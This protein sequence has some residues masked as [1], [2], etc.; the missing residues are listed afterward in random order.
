[1]NGRAHMIAG[2][3]STIPVSVLMHQVHPLPEMPT[4][5]NAVIAAAMG[6]GASVLPDLDHPRASLARKYLGPYASHLVRAA[7][8]LARRVSTT[9]DRQSFAHAERIGHDP[10]HRGLTHTLAAATVAGLL[11]AVLSIP[12]GAPPG[13]FALVVSGAWTS[14]L[15][16]D[17][18]TKAGVPLLWPLKIRGRRWY[19][20]RLARFTSCGPAD[21]WVAWS[22]SLLCASSL[23]L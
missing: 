6:A 23:M 15:V 8:A 5:T 9:T 13:T 3:A 12:F 11:A 17:A 21:W 20:V 4:L 18:T 14:H 1:M 10:D 16:L 2:A 7:S 19:R 22:W